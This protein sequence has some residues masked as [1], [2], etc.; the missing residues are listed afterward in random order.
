MLVCTVDPLEAVRAA[1]V[2]GSLKRWIS[3]FDGCALHGRLF[4]ADGFR[5]ST[6]QYAIED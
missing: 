3:V 1:L 2:H 5:A 6:G 4:A